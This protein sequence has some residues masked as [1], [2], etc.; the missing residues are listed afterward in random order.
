MAAVRHDSV[1]PCADEAVSLTRPSIPVDAGVFRTGT[2][3]RPARRLL[4]TAAVILAFFTGASREVARTMAAEH[5]ADHAGPG[6]IGVRRRTQ[7][8]PR[9][10]SF[11]PDRMQ[12][13]EISGPAGMLISIETAT[14]WSPMQPA[15]LRMGLMV[16]E[17]YRLRIGGIAGRDGEEVFPSVRVLAKLAAPPGTAWRFPVE[18]A[19]DD[20]DLRTA[21]GGSLVRRVVYASCEPER[22]DV[23][24]GA[25]FDVRPGDDA[26]EVARTLGDPVAEV[27]IGNRVP[28]RDVAP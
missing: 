17:P 6:A 9:P 14:G 23:V 5:V 25:W 20:D 21:L 22:P 12:P 11:L 18:I 2:V 1:A 24:P 15:P 19:V 4:A 3:L 8:G 28:A 16:G 10:E 7:P 26:L 27:V 13:V